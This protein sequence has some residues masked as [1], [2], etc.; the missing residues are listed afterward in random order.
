M[1]NFELRVCSALTQYLKIIS[2]LIELK[3]EVMEMENSGFQEWLEFIRGWERN[4]EAGKMTTIVYFAPARA[5]GNHFSAPRHLGAS[6]RVSSTA[7]FAST[8]SNCL[9]QT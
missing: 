1:S 8:Q 6:I 7:L 9:L 2:G 3:P 5:L 4:V